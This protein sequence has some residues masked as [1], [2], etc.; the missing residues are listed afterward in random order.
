M[1]PGTYRLPGYYVCLRISTIHPGEAQTRSV[2]K[3]RSGVFATTQTVHIAISLV[4]CVLTVRTP[5]QESDHVSESN[6]EYDRQKAPTRFAM[7]ID[8]E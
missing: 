8:R 3:F 5:G 4:S 1:T 7:G 2:A 6:L